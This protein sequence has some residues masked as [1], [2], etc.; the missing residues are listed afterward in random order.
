MRTST[1]LRLRLGASPVTLGNCWGAAGGLLA[2][3]TW[4]EELDVQN[5]RLAGRTS[6]SPFDQLDL[7]QQGA[8]G[9]SGMG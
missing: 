3:L 2:H 6:M 1:G 7:E 8:G 4:V 5:R 9:L